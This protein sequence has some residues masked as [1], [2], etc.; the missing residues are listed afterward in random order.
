MDINFRISP[1]NIMQDFGYVESWGNGDAVAPDGWELAGTAGSIAKESTVKKI[2]NYAMK[3]TAGSS[4]TYKA[5]YIYDLTTRKVRQGSQEFL[6][7]VYWAGRTVKFGMWVKCDTATKARIYVDDGITVSNSSYHTGSDGWEFLEIEKQI[8]TTFSKINF[9]AEVTNNAVV[10]YFDGGIACEGELIF[11]EF[12]DTNVYVNEDAWSSSIKI[13]A[14]KYDIARVEGQLVD[15][16]KYSSNVFKLK[17]HIHTSDLTTSRTLYDAIIRACSHGRKFLHFTDDRY[18]RVF[19]NGITALKYRAKSQVYF[20]SMNFI[21]DEPFQKY[22]SFTRTKTNIN[23][24][25]TSFNIE[26]NGSVPTFPIINFKPAGA[27]MTS[28]TLENLT[29]GEL[30]TY[31]ENVLAGTT[32][33]I[34]TRNL[35]VLNAAVDGQSYFTGDFM[36]MMP[37]TNYF[38]YTGTVGVTIKIDHGDMWL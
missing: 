17:F 32:L 36:R 3:I 2:G 18:Y 22:V 38:K 12:Q 26:N 9:G 14:T 33:I 6:P 37:G 10:A 4:N 11:T 30:F 15:N 7:S 16:V 13:T 31:N 5:E 20:F 21:T 19:V 24:S 25:P 28:C 23:S 8:A 29:T 1:Q 35:D 34:D 27:S